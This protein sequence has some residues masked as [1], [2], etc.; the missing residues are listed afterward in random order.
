MA[1]ISVHKENGGKLPTAPAKAVA[2]VTPRAWEP[3]R[4]M[5]DLMRWDP[6]SEMLPAW[7]ADEPAQFMPAFEVKETKDG[8]VFV[9]DMP[10]VDVKD[11]DIKLTHNRLAVTGKREAEKEEKT[12]TYYACERSY[13][14]FSRSFTL[15]EGIDAEQ[16]TADLKDGVLTLTLP[17]RPEAKPKQIDV[18]AK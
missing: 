3:F 4:V 14:S 18:K 7:Q 9:A 15:P 6:F 5:R 13:G 11:L 1:T 17:K 8:F 2:A 12:D 10:G 16:I